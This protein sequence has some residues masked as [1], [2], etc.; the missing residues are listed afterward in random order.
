M[1]R[2]GPS[3]PVLVADVFMMRRE[4]PSDGIVR[5]DDARCVVVVRPVPVRPRLLLPVVGGPRG[6]PRGVPAPPPL[7]L[8]LLRGDAYT[9]GTVHGQVHPHARGTH[10]PV[11]PSHVHG[12]RERRRIEQA[13]EVKQADVVVVVVVLAVGPTT[14][15]S[16]GPVSVEG[17]GEE[18]TRCHGSEHET[19]HHPAQSRR[20]RAPLARLLARLRRQRRCCPRRARCRR[21]PVDAER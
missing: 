18:S 13:E 19:V 17:G 11:R 12:T 9:L 20:S 6:V 16:T 5:A 21:Q 10:E 8:L 15:Q 7:L 2:G 4:Y 3:R 14:A 1:R